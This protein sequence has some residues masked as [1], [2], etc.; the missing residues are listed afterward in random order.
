MPSHVKGRYMP[1]FL[2]GSN[3]GVPVTSKQKAL[4]ADWIA[5]FTSTANMTRMARAAA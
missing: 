2:G 4:A 1:T 5:A 3:L